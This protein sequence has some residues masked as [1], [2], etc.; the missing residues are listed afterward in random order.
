[1]QKDL[2]KEIIT[3]VVGKSSEGIAYLLDT[4]KHVNEFT[5]A[6]KLGITINQTRNL[7]YK[8]SDLG[9]VSSIRKKDKKKGWYTY[10]WRLENVRALEFLRSFLNKKI[11][12]INFQLKSRESKQFYTCDRCKLEFTE[13]NALFINFTCNECGEV[14]TLKDNSKVVKELKKN[15]LKFERELSLV[16]EEI[17]KEKEKTDKQRVKLFA[18]EKKEKEKLRAE[19]RKEKKKERDKLAPK[20]KIVKLK[21]KKIVKLK[22]KR[23]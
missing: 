8:L 1:M 19:K 4:K 14:F 23:K 12:Q 21:K 10:F 15:L 13:E 2:I 5:I 3:S 9:L 17:G 7:L 6:D 18:K 11:E 16:E 22:K 20:K